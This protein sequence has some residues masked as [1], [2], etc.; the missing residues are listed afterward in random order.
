MNL[1]THAQPVSGQLSEAEMAELERFVEREAQ[2]ARF[3]Y[4]FAAGI[5]FVLSHTLPV[6]GAVL[7]IGTGKGRF[8]VAL[9]PFVETMTTV[10]ISAQEQRFARLHARRA[11][12]E[13]KIHFVVQDAACLPW[14]NRSFDAVVTMNAMHHMPHFL[15]VLEEMKRVAKPDGKLVL[16]DLSSHGFDIMAQFHQ[17]E[18]RVHERHIHDFR[19]IQQRLCDS[20]W[21]AR[22]YTTLLQEVLVAQIETG[23]KEIT[24]QAARPCR[25]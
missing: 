17:G 6:R 16:A 20:G 8:M 1:D 5:D 10:D 24:E 25:S 9:A 14:P 7:E 11:G 3:G 21:K 22:I 15:D 12:V 2:M 18:G 4:D 13:P 23:R 19:A